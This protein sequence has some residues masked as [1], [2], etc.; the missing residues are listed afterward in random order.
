MRKPLPLKFEELPFRPFHKGRGVNYAS[1]IRRIFNWLKKNWRKEFFISLVFLLA[2]LPEP[3]QVKAI[4]PPVAPTYIQSVPRLE[5]VVAVSFPV[6]EEVSP[7]VIPEP[8]IA[9]V[10]VPAA[11][12]SVSV[13][14]PVVGATGCGDTIYKQFIYQHESGC[15][16]DAVN[17]IGACGL[18]Q[19][20]PCS[21]MG[22]SLSDWACQDAF[23]TNYA[24]SVY[25][26]WAQAYTFWISHN[27]W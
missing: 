10:V 8:P 11:P 6:P 23:F 3:H 12:P 19:A 4:A 24:N 13:A 21:K 16:T 9:P 2:L 7:V 15:R 18:G 20:L 1:D 5:P 26:G 25:G 17:E 14:A 27:W 22:C